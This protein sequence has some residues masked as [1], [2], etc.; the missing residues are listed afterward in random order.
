MLMDKEEMLSEARRT[1]L[2][3]WHAMGEPGSDANT[4]IAIR[5]EAERELSLTTHKEKMEFRSLLMFF[6]M[7][8]SKGKG[9]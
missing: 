2:E 4:A 5:D 7:V 8:A 9:A 3:I 6:M 1:A